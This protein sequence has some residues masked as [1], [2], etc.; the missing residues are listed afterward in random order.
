MF[1]LQRVQNA[2]ADD[3]L[4]ARVNDIIRN[5]HA[6]VDAV[7]HL[8]AS[9]QLSG[10]D[11]MDD[12]DL[13]DDDN[14]AAAGDDDDDD[15]EAQPVDEDLPEA[16]AAAIA[17]AVAHR[18]ATGS[19]ATASAMQ[20]IL[21]NLFASGALEEREPLALTEVLSSELAGAHVNDAALAPLLAEL[22]ELMPAGANG[23]PWEIVDMLRSPQFQQAL[24]QLTAALNTGELAAV[25][26]QCG[27]PL[28][29]DSELASLP[30]VEVFVRAFIA[31][32]RR[33]T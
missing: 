25:L 24:T 26:Q 1:Y 29:S 3:A 11:L 12:D 18:P 32:H 5:P 10:E 7:R 28:P 15:D 22:Y 20:S 33:R 19:A 27:L 30:A 6:A 17:A 14:H 2:P 31:K 23:Q 16:S 13:Y 4:C 21:S 9:F 8:A